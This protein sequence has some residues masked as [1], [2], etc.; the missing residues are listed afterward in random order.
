M[1]AQ[2]A[3]GVNWGTGVAVDGLDTMDGPGLACGYG[4]E[5]V[6]SYMRVSSDVPDVVARKLTVTT[7]GV[8]VHYPAET[9]FMN[10]ISTPD[11]GTFWSTNTG[12]TFMTVV[13]EP[14]SS[15]DS[16]NGVG[17]LYFS[18]DDDAPPDLS[19]FVWH[20]D[21]IPTSPA[22][23]DGMWETSTYVLTADW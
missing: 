18:Y 23:A 21:E 14:D 16:I 5:C 15:V 11:V 6:L 3:D 8:T 4:G 10:I 17:D 20:G 22:F 1:I 12:V 13:S 9:T 7:S 2:S 19:V